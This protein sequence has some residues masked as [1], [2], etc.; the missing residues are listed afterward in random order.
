MFKNYRHKQSGE[1]IEATQI[2]D[3]WFDGDYPNPL[4]PIRITIDPIKRI[5]S[6]RGYCMGSGEKM[7]FA[8]K[9]GNWLLRNGSGDY[10]GIYTDHCFE[11]AFEPIPESTALVINWQERYFKLKD[12]YEKFQD[13]ANKDIRQEREI[14]RKLADNFQQHILQHHS[15]FSR[16]L[17]EQAESELGL[18]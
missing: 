9:V 3:E 16:Y 18:I 5:I 17:I 10:L 2:T 7:G 8:G 12:E 14:L 15:D 6:G 11:R 4:H 13:D 1:I